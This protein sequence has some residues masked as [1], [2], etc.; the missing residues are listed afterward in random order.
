M[1]QQQLQTSPQTYSTLQPQP[2]DYLFHDLVHP[3]PATTGK[4][5]LSY[6][7]Y[8]IPTI[9]NERNLLLLMFHTFRSPV[10]FGL[11]R[12]NDIDLE[13]AYGVCEVFKFAVEK[14]LQ[15][16]QPTLPVALFYQTV[17]EAL[18]EVKQQGKSMWKLAPVI[19]GILAAN[20]VRDQHQIPEQTRGF[21]RV[22]AQMCALLI[23]VVNTTIAGARNAGHTPPNVRALM[24]LA[25]AS[26]FP[27]LPESA[28]A[29]LPHQQILND[30]IRLVFNEGLL[31]GEVFRNHAPELFLLL[32]TE[33]IVV[34]NLNRL[35]FLIENCY[36]HMS[37]TSGYFPG[38]SHANNPARIE[39]SLARL[40]GFSKN[41]NYVVALGPGTFTAEELV[42]LKQILFSYVI[43]FQGLCTLA[44]T[45]NSQ[46]TLLRFRFAA[47]FRTVLN[48]L[49][50]LNFILE[51]IGTGG[52]AAY[53]FVY[54]TALDGLFQLDL[55]LASQLPE[56][57]A[58]QL[59]V[60]NHPE[61]TIVDESKLL[62]MLGYSE[63]LVKLTASSRAVNRVA[64]VLILPM[65]EGIIVQKATS[66]K[67]KAVVESAH[68]V[69][70]SHIAATTT[71]VMSLSR[72]LP[73]LMVVLDQFPSV[74]SPAQLNIAVETL[75]KSLLGNCADDYGDS[76]L[77]LLAQRC[78]ATEPGLPLNPS[79]AQ[80]ILSHQQLSSAPA[81]ELH[82]NPVVTEQVT[83][84]GQLNIVESLSP[85]IRS[86]LVTALILT[87]PYIPEHKLVHWL[88]EIWV[89][90][91][92]S[93]K[94]E[95]KL[96]SESLG[97]C[98]GENL[99]LH[100]ANTAIQWWFQRATPK[101]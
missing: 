46:A 20:P 18:L 62:F 9:K 13:S 44:L 3:Q 76:L 82:S 59:H 66:V 68:S 88:D 87:V 34:K 64:R 15:V 78:A 41:L 12:G 90:I 21:A 86:S 35:S 75:A 63:H 80:S 16:S 26:A 61:Y 77:R 42:L 1:M 39:E 69:I 8:Y 5:L 74:L 49:F 85:T 40:A 60:M 48:C 89:L 92:R 23:E 54:F 2:L 47:S 37:G 57:F 51:K 73:Y 55:R 14:K 91:M 99:D 65:A 97:N 52:F 79:Y 81:T 25:S 36:L 71:D 10:L 30:T 32:M 56:A 70:L 11:A 27:L 22:D 98:I 31:N 96:L 6:L 43:M 100:R 4:Q 29:K 83:N 53:N 19:A 72:I 24:L 45:F 50:D 101:L 58:S 67:A 38:G 7:A 28:R 17:L 33:D 95:Q 94:R 84:D 93:D